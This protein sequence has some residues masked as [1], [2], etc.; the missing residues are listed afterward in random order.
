MAAPL[1]RTRPS[2]NKQEATAST[3]TATDPGGGADTAANAVDEADVMLSSDPRGEDEEEEEG[4]EGAAADLEG[5]V[6]AGAV[7]AGAVGGG[8]GG[9]AGAPAAVLVVSEAD[10]ASSM[11]NHMG[12]CRG[13]G[14]RGRWC[15]FVTNPTY[16]RPSQL[17]RRMRGGTAVHGDRLGGGQG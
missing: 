1:L 13:G 17:A 6:G 4:G 11:R 14:G 7:G 3:T 12:E 16:P 9:E 10:G 5:G 2:Q 15:D 8:A